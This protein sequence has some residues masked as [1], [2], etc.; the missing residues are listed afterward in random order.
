[1][2]KGPSG[3]RREPTFGPSPESGDERQRP[4]R[5]GN[6]TSRRKKKRRARRFVF[7]RLIYWTFTLGVWAFIGGAILVAYEA[8]QLPPI[9]QLAVPKRPPNI[10]IMSADGTLLANR[11][12]TGGAAVHLAE[13]PSYLPKAFIAIEDR[14]F[15][16]HWGID[17]LGILRA[18]FNDVTAAAVCRVARRS[19]SSSPR[20]CF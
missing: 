17:P 15:Y 11:G 20:T 5:G 18:F 1:M 12:D 3:E 8:A 7:R 16:S 14:R 9:G 2:A 4:A 6:G 13:L 19:R 10:A